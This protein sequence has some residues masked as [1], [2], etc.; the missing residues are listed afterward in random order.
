[1]TKSKHKMQ[2]LVSNPN[3]NVLANNQT[4]HVHLSLYVTH[5]HYIIVVGIVVEIS[6]C[7]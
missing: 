1:M 2:G 6:I 4:D 7:M 3:F 5:E